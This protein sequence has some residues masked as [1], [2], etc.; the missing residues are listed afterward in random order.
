[1]HLDIQQ[2]TLYSF[3]TS[4]EFAIVEAPGRSQFKN[5]CTASKLQVFPVFL[6]FYG[7]LF[8]TR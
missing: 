5:V 8:R 2:M 4:H 1:M 6:Y 3:L 7:V